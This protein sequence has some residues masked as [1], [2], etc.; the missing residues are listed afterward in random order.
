MGAPLHFFSFL[1]L[2]PLERINKKNPAAPNAVGCF[3]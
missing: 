2:Q 3:F 1:R